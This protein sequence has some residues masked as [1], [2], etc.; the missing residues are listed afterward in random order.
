MNNK[1]AEFQKDKIK[2]IINLW[3]ESGKSI[4]K[5]CEEENISVNRFRY[6][7]KKQGIKLR[8]Q[9]KNKPEGSFVPLIIKPDK[10][11]PEQNTDRIEIFYPNGIELRLPVRIEPGFIK[12]LIGIN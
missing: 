11:L 8:A 10:Q 5:F 4:S 6:Q 12:T 9:H 7:L 3:K 2:T 1:K